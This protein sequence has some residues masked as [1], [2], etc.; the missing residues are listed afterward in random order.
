MKLLLQHGALLSFFFLAVLYF[1]GSTSTV[2]MEISSKKNNR[3]MKDTTEL[4]ELLRNLAE[5]EK[6]PLLKRHFASV[7]LMTTDSTHDYTFSEEHLE[8]ASKAL[9]F[10]KNEGQKWET[11]LEGARPLVMAFTSPTDGKNSFYW[12]FLPKNFDTGRTDYAFYM[13]LHG[14]GFGSNDPPWKMLYHYLQ[15][16]SKAGI[17]QMNRREGFM[18]YPWGRGDKGYRGIAET[19]IWECLQDFDNMF[20]T[21]PERQFLYGFSMGGGGT[22]RLAQQSTDRWSAIGIYSGAMTPSQEE[23]Q[24]FKDLPVWIVWGEKENLAERNRVFKDYLVTANLEVWWKE[25]KD[26]GHKY[27]YEYQDSLMNWFLEHPKN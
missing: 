21:D 19:D 22:Y 24:K 5:K 8:A 12:L 10:F 26:T 3:L 25:I 15:P 13:E 9:I 6:N 17:A 18:I 7:L 20:I 2:P 16:D 27:L 14:S 4:V 1:T 11:Y 23:V